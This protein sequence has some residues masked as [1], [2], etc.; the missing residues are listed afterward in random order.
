MTRSRAVLALMAA[1]L[2]IAGCGVSL[3]DEPERIDRDRATPGTT[4]P[5]AE[6]GQL[7]ATVYLVRDDRLVPVQRRLRRT[8]GTELLRS[9]FAGPLADERK[10]GLRTAL[11]PGLAAGRVSLV[12]SVAVVEVPAQVAQREGPDHVLAVAQI[13]FTLTTAE[14]VRSVQLARSGTPTPA[15]AG[16][17]HLVV[18]PLTR[19]DFV[20]KA[21]TQ[22]PGRLRRPELAMYGSGVASPCVPTPAGRKLTCEVKGDRDECSIEIRATS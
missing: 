22:S 1:A 11:L 14:G 10:L 2:L 21:P 9:L 8:D 3:Q 17:G 19:A 6:A 13:V 20:D 16:D 7:E 18:R 12:D 15:P 4:A 5:S